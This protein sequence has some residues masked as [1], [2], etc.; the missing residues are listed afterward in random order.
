MRSDPI[1]RFKSK[2]TA[3]PDDECWLWRGGLRDGE[4]GGF[5]FWGK[6]QFAHRMSYRL[7]CGPIPPEKMVCHTCDTPLCVNPAHLW[8]GSAS[9][10]MRDKVRKGRDAN[11]KGQNHGMSKLTDALVLDA[12]RRWRAGGETQRKIAADIGISPSVLCLIL[13]GRR[14]QH[15]GG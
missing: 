12:K 7:F 11:R 13:Q 10:N 2:F 5:W 6:N 1:A 4:Y 9:D 14:W 8:L 3:G 15:V